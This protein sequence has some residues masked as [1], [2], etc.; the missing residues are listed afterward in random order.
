MISRINVSVILISITLCTFCGPKAGKDMPR[1]LK[2]K[3][4][5]YYVEGKRLYIKHCS[6]CHQKNGSGLVRLYPPIDNPEY[7]GRD[8]E[9]TICIIRNGQ[10]GKV[11]INGISFDQPMPENRDLTILEIAELMTYLN[12]SWSGQ[13][14]RIFS[15]IEIARVLENCP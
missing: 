14:S 11:F 13:D 1:A 9:S 2:I 12:N 7:F 6:N 15:T 10:K 5:Q 3:F 4:K 8:Y